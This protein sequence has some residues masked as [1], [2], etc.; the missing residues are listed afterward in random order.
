MT[1]THSFPDDFLW[2]VATSSYQIEGAVREDGR[3]ES[4][5]DRFSHTPGKVHAN[6]NGDVACDHYHR[7]EEDLDLLKSLGVKSYRFSI[8]WP[9]IFPER[10]KL[11]QRGL[12]FYR[13][14]IQGLLDRG[15]TPAAT[16]YHWD[17]PQYLEDEGGWANRATAEAFRDYA[18]VVFREFGDLV[19]HFITHNEPWCAA[20]LSYGLG[21]H[22]PGKTDWE[23]AA[24]AAHHILLSHGL[25]VQTYR[26]L[27]YDG[28]IGITLNLSHIETA[29]DGPEDNEA[30]DIADAFSNRWFLDPIFKATY[31]VVLR[32]TRFA[33]HVRDWSFIE[34]GDLNIISAP[35]DFLGVNYYTRSVVRYT[36]DN[37]MRGETVSPTLPVT[38]MGW[39]IY[40]EGLYELLK[41]VQADYT[42]ELPLYVTE[43][44]AA[45]PDELVDGQVED[46][47]RI[48]FLRGHFSSVLRFIREGGPLKGYYVWSLMDNFEWAEGYTKRF[49]LVYV[50]YDSQD[51]I[52]KESAKWY[53][54]V[55]QSNAVPV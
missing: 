7:L 27:G 50:D 28:E 30:R 37:V 9:R 43:N 5:W 12:D 55:I 39:E 38:E 10:D 31:P 19:P 20:F 26:K 54:G 42:G 51:R 46:W 45:F 8:A 4:I 40:P 29:T 2:G 6:E 11:E 32:E 49:G 17:L 25:A 13:R 44:G 53:A 16:L 18:E 35:I 34:P 33:E 22:A 47:D 15:I 48:E 24:R 1:S 52:L 23:L 41:R 14:L 21:I 3:G 36:E